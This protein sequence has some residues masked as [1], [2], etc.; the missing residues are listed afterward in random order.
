MRSSSEHAELK[1]DLP[2]NAVKTQ[3]LLKFLI[4]RA[5]FQSSAEH[6]PSHLTFRRNDVFGLVSA[7]LLL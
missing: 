2:L 6:I 5:K 7:D 4:D 1:K 3:G